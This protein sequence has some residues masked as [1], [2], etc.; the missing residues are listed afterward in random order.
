MSFSNV[1]FL[2]ARRLTVALLRIIL[3]NARAFRRHEKES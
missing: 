3:D 1:N 2:A